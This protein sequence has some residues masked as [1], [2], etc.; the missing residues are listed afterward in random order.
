MKKLILVA[1]L[2]L[3]IFAADY[4]AMTMEEMQAMRG[5]VPVE[6]RAAFQAE[7]QTRMQAL[8]PEERQAATATMRQSKSG[9][10]DG[11]GS[12]MRKG[13]GSMGSGTGGGGGKQFRGGR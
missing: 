8:S 1:L 2:S 13:G 12:Q 3:N 10:A 9:P 11:T 7:M 5:T 4:T 6:D